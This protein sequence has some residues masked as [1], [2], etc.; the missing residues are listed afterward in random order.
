VYKIMLGIGVGVAAGWA[1]RSHAD[2]TEGATIRLLEIAM[3]ARDRLNQWAAIERERL[4]DLLA[5][6]R[7]RPEPGVSR[8][9]TGS[10]ASA[11]KR[12]SSPA[13]AS[14]GRR[15]PRLV[16]QEEGA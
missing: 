12:R 16:K 11:P 1:A 13:R 5:E 15:G 6:A 2:S 8:L 9:K 10:R 4:D 14:T 7:S 3:D